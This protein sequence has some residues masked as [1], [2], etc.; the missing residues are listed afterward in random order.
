MRHAITPNPT[1]QFAAAVDN[2]PRLM[3]RAIIVMMFFGAANVYV[4]AATLGPDAASGTLHWQIGAGTAL[5]LAGIVALVLPPYE[6]VAQAG[7]ILGLGCIGVLIATAPEN[8]PGTTPF[9]FLWPSLFAAYFCS[10]RFVVAVMIIMAASATGALLIS[11]YQQRKPIAVIGVVSSVGL[12]TVAVSVMRRREAR[13]NALLEAAANTDPLTG[14]M[15]RRALTPKLTEAVEQAAAGRGHFSVV[16]FDLDHFKR[17]NDQHGHLGGDDAL[18]RMAHVLRAASRSSDHIARFGGE[19]FAVVLPGAGTPMARAYGERV[20][21]ALRNEAVPASL[22]LS[23]SVGVAEFGERFVTAD[24]L[25]GAADQ[26][27]YAAKDAGRARVAWWA[28]TIEIGDEIP[29]P[30]P[31]P[32]P[33]GRRADPSAD[34]RGDGF[35]VPRVLLDPESGTGQRRAGA[36][37]HLRHAG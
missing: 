30:D 6:R 2:Q 28:D 4:A 1:A 13:L 12:A 18:R 19:E 9:F 17:F 3:R 16:L 37:E 22:R 27:L 34:A 25:I 21:H 10:R 26:A 7:A 20:V 11:E 15:N 35:E 24:Q 5:L 8:S 33:G 36:G 31:D 23:S 32:D 29:A 14:L